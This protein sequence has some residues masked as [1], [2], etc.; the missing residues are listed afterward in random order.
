MAYYDNKNGYLELERLTYTFFKCTCFQNSVHATQTH[1]PT[2][3][4][5][6]TH[7]HTHTHTFTAH[8]RTHTH[9]HTQHAHTHTHTHRV[10]YQ[11]NG[12][13]EKV[14]KKK[15]FQGRFKRT[16]RGGMMDRNRELIPDNW[17]LVRERTGDGVE[18]G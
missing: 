18:L 5:T 12:T 1:T 2:S 3:T 15:G 13:E 16:D 6:H 8:T 7:T 11:G 17:S 4:L 9:T 10:I 14:F